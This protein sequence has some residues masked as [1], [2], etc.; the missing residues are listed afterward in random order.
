MVQDAASQRA[1]PE[2]GADV[3]LPCCRWS[4]EA[5]KLVEQEAG[6]S[7]A[8]PGTERAPSGWCWRATCHGLCGDRR[9]VKA[10]AV[11]RLL[12][13]RCQLL[14]QSAL[15]SGTNTSAIGATKPLMVHTGLSVPLQHAAHVQV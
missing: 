6:S 5:D 15:G 3:V 9:I 13:A 2:H 4:E 7:A 12:H 11:V 1:Q 14:L 10:A 8:V